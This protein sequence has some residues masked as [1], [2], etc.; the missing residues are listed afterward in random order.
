MLKGHE[1]QEIELIIKRRIETLKIMETDSGFRDDKKTSTNKLFI[2]PPLD[3]HLTRIIT[4]QNLTSRNP[5]RENFYFEKQKR[6]TVPC[7]K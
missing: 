1:I 6:N 3:V 2:I 5:M 4:N 7:K